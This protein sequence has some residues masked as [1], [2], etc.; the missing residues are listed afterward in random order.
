MIFGLNLK[1]FLSAYDDLD[2]DYNNDED[3]AQAVWNL[4]FNLRRRF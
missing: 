2:N 1:M 3:P 4:F